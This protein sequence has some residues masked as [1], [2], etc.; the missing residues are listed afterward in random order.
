MNPNTNLNTETPQHRLSN[1]L[2]DNTSNIPE[3]DYI[4]MQNCLA[5]INR[6]S[7]NE[8]NS[9]TTGYESTEVTTRVYGHFLSTNELLPEDVLPFQKKSFCS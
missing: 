8:S 7:S 9:E 5:E 1:L 2:H 6:N 3:Q 4:D